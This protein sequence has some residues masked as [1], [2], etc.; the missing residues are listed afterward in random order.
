M[1]AAAQVAAHDVE[2]EEGEAVVA[3]KAFSD[4]RQGFGYIG[5]ALLLAAW[6]YFR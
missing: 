1:A 3:I 2:A 5:A 6:W 4:T